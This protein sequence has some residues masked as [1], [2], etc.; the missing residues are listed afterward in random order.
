MRILVVEDDPAISAF[1]VRG[2]REEHYL[3][4]LA[5][6][7]PSAERCLADVRYDAV[8]LDVQL[9]GRSGIDVCRRLREDGQA[10]PVLMLTARDAVAD[11]VTGLDAGADDYLVKPFA[12]DELLARVRALVRRGAVRLP[13]HVLQ[14]GPIALDTEAHAASVAGRSLALSA[15]EYRLLDYLLRHAGTVVSRDQLAERVWGSD[16]DLSSNVTDVYVGYL[17]R[18]LKAAGLT[19]P[20]IH[21]IRGLGYIL[22]AAPPDPA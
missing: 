9:P 16:V 17:R 10:V 13:G 5:E 11:R 15:T 8:V 6:D 14:C 7:G 18:K 20:M 2:L 4:D 3:V 22:K 21:T 12:F 19:A 1:L